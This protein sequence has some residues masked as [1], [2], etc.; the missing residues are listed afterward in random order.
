MKLFSK[1]PKEVEKKEEAKP[2][3]KQLW[4]VDFNVVENG[5]DEQ[6]V[7]GFVNEMMRQFEAST[8]SSVRSILKNAVS[9]AEK[10]AASI[11]TRAEV[12]A[13]EE[14]ARILAQA[15][16]KARASVKEAQVSAVGN[17]NSP[18]ATAEELFNRVVGEKTEREAID[19]GLKMDGQTMFVGEV[20][21]AIDVPVDLKMVSALYGHL[22]TLPELRILN[23]RG[24]ATRGTVVTVVLNKPLPLIGLI[25]AR[26]PNIEMVPD[27]EKEKS[28]LLSPGKKP[29]ARRIKLI[30]KA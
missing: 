30:Q 25:S 26:M 8:P 5:L 12:E 22:Q 4:G 23:T 16:E 19:Y 18:A 24:S 13:Q 28:G 14:A 29:L 20:E 1:R 10:I 2:R 7:V 21:L 15:N 6:Q 9:D 27:T 11:K 3:T 17:S